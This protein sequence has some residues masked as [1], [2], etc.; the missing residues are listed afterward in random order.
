LPDFPIV[1]THVHLY[2]PNTLS[3]PWVAG[4]PLLNTPY[5]PEDYSRLS[6]GFEIEKLVF[7]EVDVADGQN[8]DEARWVAAQADRDPRI[9]GIVAAMPMERG[10]AIEAQLAEYAKLPLA[11][12]V[13]RLIQ[14][15]SGEPGW[16]LRPPFVEAVQL[17]PR[18][19]LSFDLCIF[20][21]QLADTIELVRRCPETRFVLDHIGKPQIKA[22]IREPWWS[23]I[24]LLARE[25]NVWCK[26]SGVVTE[27]DHKA[28]TYDQVAPYVARAVEAFGFDRVMFGSDWPVS[29]LATSFA[30]WVDLVDRVTAGASPDD[31]RKLYRGNA[32]AFYR[33]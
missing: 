5:L 26:I 4:V 9:A 30:G 8:L 31:L 24:A 25:S 16:C 6:A 27:A 33:L 2:D 7:V 1:D 20:S 11:R 29:E 14:H 28:W 19:G 15:H 13:R 23:E 21:P 10:K 32:V 18:Y 22:G 17:L 3:Y 12:G